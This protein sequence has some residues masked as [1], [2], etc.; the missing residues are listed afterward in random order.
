MTDILAS[1]TETIHQN[2]S[3][4]ELTEDPEAIVAQIAAGAK[5]H[6]DL[7]I[8]HAR[9]R[10]IADAIAQAAAGDIVLIAGKGHENYIESNGIKTPYS[11]QAVIDEVLNA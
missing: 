3:L 7:K 5:G 10:A 11:D 2:T 6:T 8:E 9:D 1:A 4:V